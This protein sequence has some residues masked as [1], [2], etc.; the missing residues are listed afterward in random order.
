MRNSA[1]PLT[2][3]GNATE[4]S[5]EVSGVGSV[6]GMGRGVSVS[7]GSGVGDGSGVGRLIDVAVGSTAGVDVAGSTTT[8][9]SFAP[10]IGVAGPKPNVSTPSWASFS[11]N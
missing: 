9:G 8:T 6:V 1:C 7:N 3:T 11:C 4:G 5:W 10:G 2:A